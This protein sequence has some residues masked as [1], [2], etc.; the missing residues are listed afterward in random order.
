M[1]FGYLLPDRM[2]LSVTS[3]MWGVGAVHFLRLSRT[4]LFGIALLGHIA[5]LKKYILGFDL[6]IF[7]IS[8]FRIKLTY[9]VL[10]D[11]V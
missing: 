9:S 4:C 7:R 5:A 2:A 6:V 11:L 3:L 8:T 10:F 1:L